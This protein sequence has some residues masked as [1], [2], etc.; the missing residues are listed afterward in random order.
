M[1]KKKNISSQSK[2]RQ[3]AE[4]LISKNLSAKKE[5]PS[6]DIKKL[7]KEL[8]IHQVELELQNDELRQARFELEAERNKFYDLYEY[9]PVG[10]ITIDDQSI[11]REANLTAASL[12]AI[13]RRNL[14]GKQ[15]ASFIFKDDQDVFY[16]HR[17]KLAK[18]GSK[19]SCELRLLKND[20]ELFWASL[21]SILVKDSE[22][23]LQRITVSDITGRKQAV[24]EMYEFEKHYQALFN[25]IDEGFCIVEMIFDKNEKAI[26]YRFLETNTSFEKQSGIKD[27]KGKR[28]REIAPKRE[29]FWFETYEKI[30][31]TGKPVRFVNH[32]DKL[33]RWFDIYAFRFSKPEYR[34]VAILVND[35]TERKRA[36]EALKK[37]E[38]EFRTVWENSASGM[39]ITDE[40]GTVIRVNK[41]FCKMFGKNKKEL[42]GKPLASTYSEEEAEHVMLK[43]CE[44]FRSRTIKT[45]F[46]KKLKL[47]NGKSIW[48]LVS[49]SFLE[50]ERDKPLLL[51]VFTDITNRKQAEYVLHES[52]EKYRLIVENAHD[53]IEI[54]Q[55][56]RLIFCN[57][58]FA[59][60]LGYSLDELKNISFSK[61]FTEQAQKE[62][63]QR[64]E[65]RERSEQLTS[66]Y[67]TTFLKKDGTVIDVDVKYE[68]IKYKGFPATFSIIRDI[69]ESKQAEKA[70][71]VRQEFSESILNTA[72][73]IILVLD[74]QGRIV[75]FNHYMEEVSGY[76]LSEVK[77]KDWFR[78]FLPEEDHLRIRALF[79]KSIGDIK[80]KGN[81][82]TI[83][84]K[85]GNERQIEWY[86][87]TLRDSDGNVTGLLSI[88]QDITER[89]QAENKLNISL[90]K[91]KLLFDSM[92]A[93]ITISDKSGKIIESNSEAIRLLEIP[94]GK[95][96]ERAIDGPEWR[97]I[98]SDG[99]PM[100]PEEFASTKALK[101]NKTIA[102]VEMGIVKG[103]GNIT[104]INVTASPILLENYGVMII[105]FD[106][107]EHKL[108]EEKLQQS[109]NLLKEA[110]SV[111]H[112]G[113][114]E[115]DPEIG[116]PVW[117]D[118]IFSIFGLKPQEGEPSFTDHEFHVHLDDW[119]ILKSSVTE[120]SLNGTSFNINFRITQ[121]EGKI[122]WMNAI[123]TTIKDKNGRAIKLFGTAQDITESKQAEEALHE[124][125]ERY[126]KLFE[127]ESD[128][129]M[130][131]DSET[132]RFE[133]VNIAA[134]H[135]Y[136]YNREEI[137]RLTA[138]DIS[139]EP[140]ETLA[141]MNKIIKNN[142]EPIKKIERYH[143]KK[144]GTVF[145]VE[146]SP[147]I[148]S[149]GG[150]RKVFSVVRDISERNKY[151]TELKRSRRQFRL[152]S[153]RQ[154][155]KL[156]EER[157]RISRQVHDGLGQDLT[158]LKIDIARVKEQLTDNKMQIKN[159]LTYM[160]K[161]I[162]SMI[163]I[164]KQI[165]TDLRPGIL[166]QLG[167]AAAIE[168]YAED[169][170]N[171]AG[172]K[173]QVNIKP[174]DI[175]LK[176]TVATEL[177]R[178]LQ[179]ALT[180]TARH[181]QA[182]NVNI[183]LSMDS[184][185]LRFTI[186]DNGIGFNEN[187]LDYHKSLGLLGMQER[188][189]SIKAK[190]ELSGK[191]GKGTIVKVTLPAEYCKDG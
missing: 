44:R 105:Y 112:I 28:M 133:D 42:E 55:N 81:V 3:K 128:A 94:K 13:E 8:Q 98:R 71:R 9:A 50:M 117:S 78:T 118:E 162:N 53:G 154:Q 70:L 159:K 80:T 106:I 23:T 161:R 40:N 156:E 123:G 16:F 7:I 142:A 160:L 141:M 119:P 22:D 14:S 188:A 100:P 58:Q 189:S 111:A 174:S 12:L 114:W 57:A 140:E 144:D 177:Y 126:K 96:T 90:M 46:E 15:F 43:H 183:N 85:N 38:L 180:N 131:L 59:L 108:A 99:S 152:L 79:Q 37:S 2:L 36:E 41:A 107:T 35:I 147:G 48:V 145:P 56:D 69:T 135:L 134:L 149:I 1:K 5:M 158:A 67:E 182:K 124:I 121:P 26:D 61:I 6:A 65:K 77:G 143:K 73:A 185:S 166:D 190:L 17:K 82:N 115:L 104:W 39:R 164:V 34:Q 62:L 157:K 89:K 132:Q 171:R 66:Q 45:H 74:I 47:W 122:K 75:Q 68:I 51:G 84:M 87:N 76:T 130:V 92:P 173:C 103:N 30:A 138:V 52:E 127:R 63:K 86:D 120:A 91:Y 19:L 169:F 163:Q 151:E 176:E 95:L 11:I 72:Q 49:N 97:I 125:E 4:E 172:V 170:Q 18:V 148:F 60:M 33:N 10:Y 64:T 136:G 175:V 20:G 146:I 139:A 54:T 165:S 129:I 21:E 109:E 32:A 31:L 184:K 88:G 83:I 168:W 178:I 110:Q 29:E 27:A 179:E 116:I 25:S 102:N 181:S 187:Q 101:E 150:S 186:R 137:L 153:H 167:L 93:G 24:N 155:Q 191:A 113:H